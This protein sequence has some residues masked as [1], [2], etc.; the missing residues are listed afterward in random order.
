MAHEVLAVDV[1]GPRLDD[2]SGHVE[3]QIGSRS[4]RLREV[5][6]QLSGLLRV[7]EESAGA[8]SLLQERAR[9]VG[10]IDQFL[11]TTARDYEISSTNTA[12]LESEIENLRDQVDPQ[13][14]RER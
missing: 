9:V 5:E 8:A 2:H 6:A 10:R 12:S 14:R 1:M 11:E 7:E 13:A 3:N 4:G